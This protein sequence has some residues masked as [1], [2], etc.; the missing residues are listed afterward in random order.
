MSLRLKLLEQERKLTA[1]DVRR[2]LDTG[3]DSHVKSEF[4]GECDINNIVKRYV[5]DGFVSHLAAGVPQFL[6]VSEIGDFRTA[7]EQ[8]RAASEFFDGL[9]AKVR[10]RFDN[11][12]ARFLDEAGQLTRDELR[13]LGLAEL[14]KGDR[15]RRVTDAEA[16]P[17]PD[18]E[19]AAG[20]V[21]S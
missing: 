5:R 3:T 21:S 7:V 1:L 15:E 20:T 9:P 2:P 11:D 14:R 8:V 4:A 17:S 18:G 16:A 12:P 19:E 10:A 6:D 13:E